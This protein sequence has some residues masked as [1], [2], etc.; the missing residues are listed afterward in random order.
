MW[1]SRKFCQRWSNFDCFFFCFVVFAWWGERGSKYYFKGDILH[2]PAK[3][4]WWPSIECWLD[5]I[6]IFQE[7]RTNTAKKPHIFVI[8]QRGSGPRLPHWIRTW[9]PKKSSFNGQYHILFK[10]SE[11]KGVID[12]F[13][14]EGTSN[15]RAMWSWNTRRN[16]WRLWTIVYLKIIGKM[17]HLLFWSKCSI[18]HN[19]FKSIQILT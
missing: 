2:P 7:I 17:E 4:W 15:K 8:F 16:S 19:I 1:G 12:P 14:S 18:F 10:I 11:E 3:C 6:V 5:T 13:K 9:L